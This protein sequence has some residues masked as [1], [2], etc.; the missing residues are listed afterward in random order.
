[1][2]V[3]AAIN[4][5]ITAQNMALYALKYAQVQNQTLVLLHIKNK[6]DNL[7]EIES[8]MQR[9]DNIA[10]SLNVPL[11]RV[12]LSGSYKRVIKRFL[13]T[14]F[15]DIIFCSTRKHNSFITNSFSEVLIKM[16][17]NV[18]IAV[19]RIVNMSNIMDLD[20]LMLSIKEDKLSVKKFTFFTTLASAYRAKA[21]IY[22]VSSMS[23]IELSRVDM[24]EA[25]DRLSLINYN[26]RHYLKLANIMKLPLYIKH[27]FTNSE[28]K[29]ILTHIA[30]SNIQLVVIGGKRLSVTSFFKKEMPIEILMREALINT[31]AYYQKED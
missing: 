13:S 23:R 7:D 18:D 25:R 26:L 16:N 27:N 19:V 9:I 11:E 24:H 17:L 15:V 1:M 30:K 29:S 28:A 12:I 3:V 10:I 21:E 8:S 4:G 5:S 22:S 14:N 2:K 20:S 31:I 6:K